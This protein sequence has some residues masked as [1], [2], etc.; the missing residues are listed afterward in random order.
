MKSAIELTASSAMQWSPRRIRVTSF[1]KLAGLLLATGF[2]TLFWLSVLAA[3]SNVLGWAMSPAALTG[4]G[5]VIAA[6]CGVA[7]S[8][9]MM[10]GT[11]RCPDA[12]ED[13]LIR[14]TRS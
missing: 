5:L 13:C 2:P 12:D 1:S 7:A 11:P 10:A 4:V 3:L 9:A 14:A 6:V 8:A